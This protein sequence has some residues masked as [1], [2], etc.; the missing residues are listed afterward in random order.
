MIVTVSRRLVPVTVLVL[1]LLAVTA[2]A[3]A[4]DAAGPT[5]YRSEVMA[6]DPPA[7]GVTAEVYGGDAFIRVVVESGHELLVAGYEDDPAAAPY[8]RIDGNGGVFVNRRSPAS[9]LNAARYGRRDV[10]VPDSLDPEAPPAWQQVASGGTYAWHD[11]RIHWMSPSVPPQVDA[12][13]GEAQPVLD[14]ELP[15]LVDGQRA[16]IAGTL[17]WQ[18]SRSPAVPIVVALAVLVGTVLAV[19]GRRMLTLAVVAGSGLLALALGLSEMLA[20]PPGAPADMLRTFL[21]TVALGAILAALALA[22]RGR[23]EGTVVLLAVLAAVPLLV[24]SLLQVGALTAPVLV[25]AAPDVLVR[26]GIAAVLGAG[27]GALTAGGAS[28]I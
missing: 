17:E 27:L 8:L 3:A 6:I 14:W 5:N 25:G 9:Y 15:V 28:L 22:F 13:A 2:T 10:D 4:A 26:Y 18:P 1:G 11:H 20:A 21:P 12:D 24:W 16:V 19:R 23:G 7:P